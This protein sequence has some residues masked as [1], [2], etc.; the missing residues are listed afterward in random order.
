LKLID[1]Q[2]LAALDDVRDHLA[3]LPLSEAARSRV[4]SPASEEAL[5]IYVFL[6]E[7]PQR[8]LERG[9]SAADVLCSRYYWLRRYIQLYQVAHQCS[10]GPADFE[11]IAFQ[12]MESY[13]R[14]PDEN[15]DWSRFEHAHKQAAADVE[16]LLR[17]GR[18]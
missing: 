3:Q 7:Q 9:Y 15:F 16:A 4:F 13:E 8:L 6:T 5:R 14:I 17:N 10:E 11:Q 18:A 1:E 2:A 12:I